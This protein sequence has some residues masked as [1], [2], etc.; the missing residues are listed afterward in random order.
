M[1]ER[2]C[3]LCKVLLTGWGWFNWGGSIGKHYY[4][5]CPKCGRLYKKE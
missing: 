4:Q 5:T 1:S 2:I 3:E